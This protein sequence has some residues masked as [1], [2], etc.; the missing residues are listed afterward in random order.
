MRSRW[1]LVS[2]D[3]ILTIYKIVAFW[4][5]ARGFEARRD[6][7]LRKIGAIKPQAAML[8]DLVA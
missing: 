8:A 5:R 2:K 3:E 4:A 1:K 7:V 6:V